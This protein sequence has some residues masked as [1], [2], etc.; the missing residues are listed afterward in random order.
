VVK[1]LTS[2]E[3]AF[4]VSGCSRRAPIPGPLVRR[5][6]RLSGRWMQQRFCQAIRR[7]LRDLVQAARRGQPPPVPTV[8]P[9]GLVIFRPAQRHARWNGWPAPG[10]Q[11]GS[12]PHAP[13]ERSG[14]AR[15]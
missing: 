13:A 5:G 14:P 12:Q 6:F 9:G 7:R 4:R 2:G 15:P 8:R 11:P 3:V 10:T 1:D